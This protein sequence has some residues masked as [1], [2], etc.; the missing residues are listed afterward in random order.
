MNN[1]ISENTGTAK[2]GKNIGSWLLM[3]LL[4]LLL[5]TPLCVKFDLYTPYCLASAASWWKSSLVLV[6]SI[7]FLIINSKKGWLC[8]P[9]PG[10]LAALLAMVF[11]LT[12]LTCPFTYSESELFFH[13]SAMFICVVVGIWLLLRGFSFILF[14]PLMLIGMLEAGAFIQYRSMLNSMVLVEA[15]ECSEEEFMVYVTPLNIT[16]IVLGVTII[17]VSSYVLNRLLHSIPKRALLGTVVCT[18]CSFYILYPFLPNGCTSLSKVGINGAFKRTS[19][20]Y[21]DMKKAAKA[22]AKLATSIPSP[23]AQPSSLPTLQGNEGCVIVFHIGESVRADRLSFNGFSRDTTP[24]LSKVP[25]LM[26]WKRCVAASGL[27]VTSLHVLLTNARRAEGGVYGTPADDMKATC[28]PVLDL[29]KAN[30]F[31]VRCFL[32]SLNKQSIRADKA[33]RNLTQ[34]CSKRY[35]TRGDVMDA[36]E[37]IHQCLQESGKKN[38]FLMVNNE[39]SHLPFRNYDH[40]NPPFTPSKPILQPNGSDEEAVRNAYDNTIHYTDRFVHRVLESLKGRPYVYIY[41]SDHGEYLGDYD[42][43]WGRA[44]VGAEKGFFHSTQAAAVGAFAIC[45]PEFEALNPH[46]AQ[47]VQQMRSS[48]AMQIGHEHYFHTL[49][50]LVG[51]QTP[52]YNAELDLCSPAAKP[53]DGPAPTDWPAHLGISSAP[54]Q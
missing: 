2:P 37:Q 11:F 45:S 8:L 41:V 53:Y 3:G 15:L 31:D 14:I 19:Q 18:I 21:R 39:G 24:L 47:A 34:A 32:G 35:Y 27:T 25:N 9:R 38:L 4:A 12:A 6:I 48:T 54:E 43:T 10:K 49:L 51:L 50:G 23:A 28:G 52:Y 36:T 22:D 29:F 46:F 20:S 42:G 13:S 16:L 30:G 7:I 40:E 5:L 44:R 33:L 17:A 26:S 1:D